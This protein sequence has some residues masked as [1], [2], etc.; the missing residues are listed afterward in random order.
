MHKLSQIEPQKVFKYFEE[1]SK[2]P[3]GSGN[4]QKISRY[5][6]SFA[7][8]HNLRYIKDSANN[9]IIYKDA[10]QGYENAK[11]V[12]L[13]GHMDM[14]CQKTDESLTDFEKDGIDVFV[15]GDFIKAKGT[16]LGS[17]NGIAMAMMLAVLEDKTLEHPSIEAVFTTDEEIGM[18]G[19]SKLDV[20]ILKGKRMINLDSE[21]EAALT[22]SCA[23]GID[24]K[25]TLPLT[26]TTKKG[27]KIEVQINGLKGGHSGVEI[28]KGRVN[29]N[30]LMGRVLNKIKQVTDFDIIGINGGTKRNAIPLE[31]KA[32]ILADDECK[33]INAIKEY[34]GVIKEE[35]KDREPDCNIKISDKASGEFEVFDKKSTDKIIY[36]LLTTPNG[37]VDMSKSIEGLVETSL[38]LGILKTEQ[39][40]VVM[41][42]ALRSNK[43]SALD[44]L[45][46]RL[47]CF[48]KFNE[49]D[50]ETSGRYEP[51]EYRENSP[52]RDMYI[53][54]YSNRV[55]KEPN[56]EAI[57]AGLECAVFSATINEL[58]C[59]AIGPD[60]F[61]V[62]T[63]NE[64]LSI[65]STKLI[66]EI[67]CDM[68]RILK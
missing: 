33:V 49:C 5:C 67:L 40:G 39:C 46:E 17:D 28:D 20:G 34:F 59:I 23:G 16:T 68:L 10:T 12:I 4:M 29:A 58:D 37:V 7:E 21:E 14:V 41:Q 9:V 63:V 6:V 3:R 19:A 53:Q 54:V 61:D 31:A 38:N 44:F 18:V 64:R 42:Y 57:H 15:D 43:K 55:G 48:A 66:Y 45:E 62:H 22:V 47:L 32:E 35:F 50:V 24:V 26:K 52:M 8:E 1:I 51:W 65:P 2:I 56:V 27:T 36:M 11:T 25:I 30:V 13:Q 60:M